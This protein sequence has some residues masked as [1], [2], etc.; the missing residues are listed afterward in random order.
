V[1]ELV[2]KVMKIIDIDETPVL[3]FRKYYTT[4]CGKLGTVEVRIGIN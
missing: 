4:Q 1:Y 3:V 2:E